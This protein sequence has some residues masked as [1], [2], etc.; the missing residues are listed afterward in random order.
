MCY[1]NAEMGAYT[2]ALDVSDPVDNLIEVSREHKSTRLERGCYH[3]QIG[4]P[5]W[6]RFRGA[7]FCN[8]AHETAYFVEM[9][10]ISLARL[11]ESC[12]RIKAAMA[13]RESGVS[14]LPVRE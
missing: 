6:R 7:R 4:V 10:S 13:R 14:L 9:E 2:R 5:V 3:C 12:A 11:A 1:E 8:K